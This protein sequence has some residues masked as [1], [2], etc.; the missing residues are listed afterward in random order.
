MF[1]TSGVTEAGC[2]AD[3]AAD[4]ARTDNGSQ[5]TARRASARAAKAFRSS[6][7]RRLILWFQR[8]EVMVGTRADSRAPSWWARGQGT[9]SGQLVTLTGSPSGV[10]RMKSPT[11][12]AST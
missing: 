11:A 4:Q 8:G 7:R 9:R 3:Q 1:W 12:F 2:K 6:G 5:E 10:R